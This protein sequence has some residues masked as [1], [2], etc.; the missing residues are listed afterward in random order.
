[1]HLRTFGKIHVRATTRK[2]HKAVD[3]YFLQDYPSTLKTTEQL[4]SLLQHKFKLDAHITNDNAAE[5]S[6]V[7]PFH[8]LNTRQLEDIIND[9]SLLEKPPRETKKKL[10]F[11]SNLIVQHVETNTTGCV[12]Q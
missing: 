5:Q 4:V 3:I 12:L 9:I 2:K 7:D 1:M 8:Y 10:E 6:K 11:L